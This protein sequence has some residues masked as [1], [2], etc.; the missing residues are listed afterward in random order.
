[1]IQVTSGANTWKEKST[2]NQ[3]I[4]MSQRSVLESIPSTQ[5]YSYLPIGL[6]NQIV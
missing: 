3:N 6:I 2:E 5:I 1:M 4:S